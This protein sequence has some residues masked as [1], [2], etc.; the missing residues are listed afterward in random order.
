MGSSDKM[1]FRGNAGQDG[2]APF[3]YEEPGQ[4]LM[5]FGEISGIRMEGSDGTPLAVGLWRLHESTT[6]PVYTSALGDETF[7]VLEGEVSI[8]NLDNG[9]VQH[10]AR[11]DIG[12]W[13]K[14][15]R[16]EWTFKAPFKKLVIVAGR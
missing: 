4:G 10:F 11:G 8:R 2:F 14:G 15:M 3:Q 9:E 13:S 12:S 5:T 16:T 7:L 6:S 1:F